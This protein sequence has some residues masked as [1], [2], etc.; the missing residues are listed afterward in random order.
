MRT[1]PFACLALLGLLA[2]P[3]YLTSRAALGS[4]DAVDEAPRPEV[5][6]RT[7]QRPVPEP[8]RIPRSPQA[9]PSVD[10][11]ANGAAAAPEDSDA[12]APSDETAAPE[13][14]PTNA[15]PARAAPLPEV[16]PAANP[17]VPAP[18]LPKPVLP[19]RPGP[20]P[21]APRPIT[22]PKGDL[23]DLLSHFRARQKALLELDSKRVEAEGK[24]LRDLK[25]ELGFPDFETVG[26][27]LIREGAR[28]LEGHLG[29]QAR[30]SAQLAVDLA[31]G[32]PEGWWLLARADVAADGTA[33]FVPA[34]KATYTALDTE[35]ADPLD[36]RALLG[37]LG[38]SALWAALVALGLALGLLMLGSLRY[39][40]HDFHHLFPKGASPLQTGFLGLI[41][42]ALPWLF[43]LGPFAILASLAIGSWIYLERQGRAIA[44]AALIVA[45]GAPFLLGAI[46]RSVAISPLALDL[47]TA[48]RDL[49]AENPVAHLTVLTHEPDPNL[50]VSRVLAHRAKLLGHLSEAEGFYRRALLAAPGRADIE[51]NLANVLLLEGDL[52]GAQTLYESALDH[53]PAQ[54]ATYFNL[55]QDFSRLLQLEQG[56]E[57]QRHALELDRPLIEQHMGQDPRANRYLIDLPIAFADV[58]TAGEDPS[59]AARGV[60]QQAA[61]RLF[62]PLQSV[63]PGVAILV[64]VIL[65]VLGAA[66]SALKPS[67]ACRKCGRPVCARCDPGLPGEDLCGQCVNVFL[68]KSVADPPARIRKEARV[69]AYQILRTRVLRALSLFSGGGGHVMMGEVAL[70]TVLLFA[71]VFCL[72]L[73]AG[74]PALIRAP[75][76]GIGAVTAAA[77]GAVFVAAVY[78]LS[79]RDLFGKTR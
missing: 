8:R 78:L 66:R 15:R 31:P 71:L 17:V 69:R 23:D 32:L 3:L 61:A 26:R 56:Q 5:P 67:A 54:A 74:V 39:L 53:A 12:A 46:A 19:V 14:P 11:P 27:A 43:H 36:R 79:V 52:K 50:A 47:W 10:A 13:V 68:R 64:A 77:L 28:R 73:A 57:A 65:A 35:F 21:F 18:A 25:T 2:P 72:T 33:G 63:W 34:A 1:R 29:A 59:V 24:A 22:M 7:R 20:L 41:L 51:N 55:G 6:Q 49:D 76:S 9:E 30:D 75:Q 58:A 60:R 45:L 42:L 40:L 4:I 44:A 37:D 70:G 16:R 38:V 48:D 62:G